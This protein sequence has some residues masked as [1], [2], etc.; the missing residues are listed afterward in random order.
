M[1]KTSQDDDIS[2]KAVKILKVDA[3]KVLQLMCQEI[4]KNQQLLQDWKRYFCS[5]P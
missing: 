4:W 2:T 5:N 1:N 3:A